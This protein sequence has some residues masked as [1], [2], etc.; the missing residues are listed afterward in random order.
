MLNKYTFKI[1]TM[2]GVNHAASIGPPA[3][4]VHVCTRWVRAVSSC[5]ETMKVTKPSRVRLRPSTRDTEEEER[6]EHSEESRLAELGSKMPVQCIGFCFSDSRQQ[7]TELLLE[8]RG[9][10]NGSFSKYFS[11]TILFP[12]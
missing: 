6:E 2:G 9:P 12:F 10:R 1:G 5:G 11:L 8:V 4:A 3:R 7:V